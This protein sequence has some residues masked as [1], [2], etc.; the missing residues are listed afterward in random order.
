MTASRDI[1]AL[2][3]D[4]SLKLA[5][6]VECT[7]LLDLNRADSDFRKAAPSRNGLSVVPEIYYV[8]DTNF[9]QAF[10][11]PSARRGYCRN[12]HE[13]HIWPEFRLKQNE[14][15]RL[16]STLG[17][18]MTLLAT[19][20]LIAQA[21]KF[22]PG[23]LY[24]SAG[25]RRELNTQLDILWR[26]KF[27]S[28]D[29]ATFGAAAL[30]HRS[31]IKALAR[32][33]DLPR[34]EAI[35]QMQNALNPLSELPDLAHPGISDAEFNR[36]RENFVVSE[37]C[38]VLAEEETIEP[39]DQIERLGELFQFFDFIEEEFPAEPNHK[40]EI[41]H[42][43]TIWLNRLN[44]EYD[45]RYPQIVP[46]PSERRDRDSL[47]A[48]ADTIA[49]LVWASNSRTG[50]RQRIVFITGDRIV[51]NAYRA[52]HCDQ[53][54]NV[55]FLVR[56]IAQ[57]MPQYN[58]RDAEAT[59]RHLPV[60]DETR[61]ILEALTYPLT[62]ILQSYYLESPA[63]F[64][65]QAGARVRDK[66]CVDVEHSTL[67]DALLDEL[68]FPLPNHRPSLEKKSEELDQVAGAMRL[69]E[70]ISVGA[71][72]ALVRKRVDHAVSKAT[73]LLDSL[74]GTN[75]SDSDDAIG[76]LLLGRLKLAIESGFEFSLPSAIRQISTL[77]LDIPRSPGAR[78]KA[79][80]RVYL[81]YEGEDLLA[82]EWLL[83]F[84]ASEEKQKHLLL[85]ELSK[86]P[87]RVFALA[88]WLTFQHGLWS[89]TV[90]F[91]DFACS[92]SQTTGP[93]ASAHFECLYIKAL[94]LRLRMANDVPDITRDADTWLRDLEGA[95][96]ALKR[97]I[98]YHGPQNHDVREARAISERASVRLTYCAWAAIGNLSGLSVY[99]NERLELRDLFRGAV[100]DLQTCFER[101]EKLSNS[102]SSSHR[103]DKDTS[104]L[105]T[106]G[107]VRTQVY[108]NIECARLLYSILTT[109][110]DAQRGEYLMAGIPAY[111]D[112]LEQMT[113]PILGPDDSSH[114]IL[115]AY[116]L[117][118]RRRTG[119]N[120]TASIQEI[121]ADSLS[122]ELDRAMLLEI[123][124]ATGDTRR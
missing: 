61:R 35:T 86:E 77:A 14:Y 105:D 6:L 111:R 85:R 90:R 56:P 98:D 71:V 67:P 117:S 103:R 12:F 82:G 5:H 104:R 74:T 88:S 20:F 38:R 51:L 15:Q 120:V 123:K 114:P 76:K 79:T 89:D 96:A 124:K 95:N 108:S 101:L 106:L 59:L 11:E 48:D 43:S 64:D 73:A 97:C 72:P 100:D 112:R 1:G 17:A 87:H 83:K 9:V 107:W 28:L 118:A 30:K 63:R 41:E 22:A 92:A 84:A 65:R 7:R 113:V 81:T 52:W 10:L 21:I 31:A 49:H 115:Q 68:M 3:R 37:I 54:D 4:I 66:F 42:L 93:Q 110:T 75:A 58:L 19:E 99:R 122:L 50:P 40:V 13:D 46:I 91:A 69:L 102:I 44:A 94:A 33:V 62:S 26:E 116:A 16:A 24:M 109:R 25:H 27:E 55:S 23:K 32:I 18:Q 60:F 121:P 29:N 34:A 36:M 39:A 2:R 70:R 45:S 57:Y 80:F 78:V 119:E 8:I 53:N 47:K